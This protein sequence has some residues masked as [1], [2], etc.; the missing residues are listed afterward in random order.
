MPKLTLISSKN[1]TFAKPNCGCGIISTK[2]R[3][4]F[5]SKTSASRKYSVSRKSKKIHISKNKQ[6]K[7]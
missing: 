3:K 6:K 7:I 1:L 4:L 5:I 2:Q